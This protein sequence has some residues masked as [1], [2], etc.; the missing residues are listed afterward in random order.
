MKVEIREYYCRWCK[1][2]TT[3][4]FAEFPREGKYVCTECLCEATHQTPVCDE[5]RWRIIPHLGDQKPLL[6][7]E[8]DRLN[9]ECN[10]PSFFI[11]ITDAQWDN[12][13]GAMQQILAHINAQ[14]SD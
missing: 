12:M 8:E 11:P 2:L 9:E 7:T 13:I 14:K 6:Y 10:D 5:I 1:K 3:T 4:V